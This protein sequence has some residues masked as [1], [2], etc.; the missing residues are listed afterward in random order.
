M[1]YHITAECIHSMKL[2]PSEAIFYSGFY[3]LHQFDPD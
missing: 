3:I 1:N 2:N